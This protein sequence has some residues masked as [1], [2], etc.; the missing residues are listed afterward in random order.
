M[1]KLSYKSFLIIT[2][3]LFACQNNKTVYKP[4]SSGNINTVTVVIE[5]SLWNS[6]VGE[7]IRDAFAS[8]FIGLP[9]QEPIFSLKQI[10]LSVFSDFAR[11]SRNILIVQ[12]TK[13]DT[14]M[15]LRDQF[16]KPQIVGRFLGSNEEKIID[17]I[18]NNKKNITQEIKNN[19]LKEKQRRMKISLLKQEDLKSL[20]SIDLTIPSA[21]KLFKKDKNKFIWFQK[22]T[23]NGSINIIAYQLPQKKSLRFYSLDE[24]IKTRDSIGKLFVPG[25]N[26]NSHMITEE[27]Y[28]PYRKK[29]KLSGFKSIETR[30]TWEVKNDFMAGPFLNYIIQ[31]TLNQRI[32]V[33]EG[34]VFSP[35][36]KKREQVFELEAIFKSLKIIKK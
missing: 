33:L 3:F 14:F 8:E 23:K 21:Y 10:P 16:A 29:V 34:F 5:N 30:G 32:V 35:S 15:L 17:K 26:K 25:R 13:K 1:K 9:Q 22:E 11:Q 28:M 36:S 19:D 31:D 7:A 18:K 27:A 12:K 6:S 20:F 2:C 24:I 4:E